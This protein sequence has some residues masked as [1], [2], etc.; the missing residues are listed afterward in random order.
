MMSKFLMHHLYNYQG[1]CP[2]MNSSKKPGWVEKSGFQIEPER[3]L[4]PSQFI[5]AF[6]SKGV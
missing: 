4:E 3:N 5:S 6:Y 1:I 2:V